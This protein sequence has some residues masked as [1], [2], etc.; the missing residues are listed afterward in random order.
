M[1]PH[2]DDK[3]HSRSINVGP[4]EPAPA[5]RDF[6]AARSLKRQLLAEL[7]TSWEEGQPIPPEELLSRWPT[8]PE[9]DP[10]VS[11]LLSEDYWQRR[12]QGQ[13]ATSEEY[14]CR[15]PGQKESLANLL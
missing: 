7:R 11:S 1:S 6:V 9:A 2:H 15:F 3:D 4:V 12:Q 14:A 13:Q 10:D 8:N 5:A